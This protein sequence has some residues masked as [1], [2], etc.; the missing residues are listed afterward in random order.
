M[1]SAVTNSTL[2]LSGSVQYLK[3]R[4]P[5]LRRIA[6]SVRYVIAWANVI[7]GFAVHIVRGETPKSAHL[8]LVTLFAI[9]GGKAN[10]LLARIVQTLQPPY[11]LPPPRG[12]LGNLADQDL[13]QIESK[14]VKDGYVIFE[15]CLSA[16]FCESIVR[17]TLQLECEIMGDEAAGR[18]Q[19]LFGRYDS[20]A[21]I[22]PKYSVAVD[23]TTDIAEVQQLLCDPSLLTVAQNYLRSKPIFTGISLWWSAPVKDTPDDTAAQEFHWDMERIKWLRFFV[24]LTDV[25]TDSGPH[26]FI[27]GTHVTGAIPD[28]LL[29]RGYKRIN[30]KEIIEHYGRNRYLEFIGP[31]G[32]IIAEDSRGFHKG[33][34]PRKGDRLLLAFELSNTTFGANKRHHIRNIR[35]PKFGEFAKKYPRLYANFDFDPNLLC[36]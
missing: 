32:T 20:Q 28:D 5:I 8:A 16:E 18:Q 21:P 1:R 29:E 7:V 13:A 34:M 31:R 11:P 15:K 36:N 26:C 10:D 3:A 25:T 4:W 6:R 22:A 27:K 14:L 24:Y 30:D 12:V 9:S 19:K 35:V 2:S 33:S 23:D 17:Q